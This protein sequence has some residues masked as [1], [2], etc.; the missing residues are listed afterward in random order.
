MDGV[1]LACSEFHW[2]AGSWK[3]RITHAE[4]IPYEEKWRIRLSQLYKQPIELFPKTDA[5]YGRYLGML[6]R[7]F[8][9]KNQLEAIDLVASHGHTIFHQP[10]AGFTAQIGDGGALSAECGLP[11][12]SNFRNM[13]LALGGQGAPLVPMGDRLLFGEYEA[14]LNLGGIAN[15][16][17]EKNGELRAFDI[18]PCNIVFNRVARWLGLP[19]DDKGKIASSAHIDEDLLHELNELPF[20]SKSGAKSLGREWINSEFWPLVKNYTDISEEEKMATL[21]NHVATQIAAVLNH[22]QLT[23]VLVTGGGALNEFLLSRIRSKTSCELIIPDET[24]IHFKEA[25]IFAF[26]GLLR[27]NN[28]TNVLKAVT[29]SRADHIG[30]ALWG[31]FSK[32]SNQ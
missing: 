19:Y 29:G 18:S 17:F 32:L 6:V 20:Y 8:V 25:L 28:Q 14:C 12:V 16:S 11:V 21:S 1:D 9:Q 3:Y 4:T 10:Q 13:D 5:F 30:G 31:N 26:L 7:Q 22:N 15:I 27:I 24:T 23:K 2:S